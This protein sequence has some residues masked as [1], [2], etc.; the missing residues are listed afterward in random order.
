LNQVDVA[1]LAENHPARRMYESSRLRGEHFEGATI[2]LGLAKYQ[3]EIDQYYPDRRI[4]A[5]ENLLRFEAV[6]RWCKEVFS[7]FPEVDAIVYFGSALRARRAPNDFDFSLAIAKSNADRSSSA[8]SRI[9][10]LEKRFADMA[11]KFHSIETIPV[12]IKVLDSYDEHPK[13]A[14]KF[15][16]RC[17]Y[18]VFFR[19]LDDSRTAA[20]FNCSGRKYLEER[21]A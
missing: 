13:L 11:S 7:S 12:K 2:P 8:T 9:D 19:P 14:L 6:L 16:E 18:A 4:S 5:Q 10:L 1:H 3:K 17:P 20:F 21:S 15:I